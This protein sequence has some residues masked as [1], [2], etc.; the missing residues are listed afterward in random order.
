[1]FL[2]NLPTSPSTPVTPDAIAISRAPVEVRSQIV[3]STKVFPSSSKVNKYL[4]PT[5]PLFT[6]AA[7]KIGFPRDLD[8]GFRPGTGSGER[9]GGGPFRAEA[10]HASEHRTGHKSQ[11]HAIRCPELG[12]PPGDNKVAPHTAL[13]FPRDAP[14]DGSTGYE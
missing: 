7:S 5:V 2:G 3:I 9:R 11:T 6:I 10:D 12:S 8:V 14:L 1:M 4:R 13:R